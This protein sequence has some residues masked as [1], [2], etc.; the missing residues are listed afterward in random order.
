MLVAA[1]FF[2]MVV[3]QTA[4]GDDTICATHA[5]QLFYEQRQGTGA[6]FSD[7]RLTPDAHAL[8]NAIDAARDDGLHPGDYHID[9]IRELLPFAA[10]RE[11]EIDRF[12]TD[13]FLLL[14]SHLL[15]G[16]VD[17]DTIEPT[18]CLEPRSAR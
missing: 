4:V 18:W 5:V 1:A 2:F 16:R 10:D 6:W 8:I 11:R 7:G 17:P 15:A 3:A 14:A 13:A 12:L 9:A